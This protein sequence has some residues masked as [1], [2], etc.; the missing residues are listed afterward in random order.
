MA[1]D[2]PPASGGWREGDPVGRRRSADLGALALESGAVLPGLRMA[3]ETWGPPPRDAE[4][5]VLVLHALTGDSHVVGDAGPGHPT[6]GWWPSLVGPGA[7]LDTDRFHVVAPNVLGGCQGSTG[8]SSRAP[9]GAPWGSRFP[10]VTVRDQVA[11]EALLADHLGVGAWHLVVGGSMGGMRAVEWAATHPARVQRLLAVATGA[12]ATADQIAWWSAESAAVRGDAGWR[13][14]DY[15]GA[16]PGEGPH[17]GLGLARRIAHLTYRTALE[18]ELRFGHQ[19]QPGEE[20]LGGGRFAVESYLDHAAAKLVRRFDAGSYVALSGSMRSHD[21]GRGR[22]GVARALGAV[23]AAARVVAV[24]SDRLFPP[25]LSDEL[26]AHLPGAAGVD[27]V[28]SPYG[29]DAFLLETGAVGAAARE[30]A[31]APVPRADR[32]PAPAPAPAPVPRGLQDARAGAGEP[33]P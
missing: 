23:T 25:E 4:G 2:R 31:A 9:D 20:P 8:P 24:D 13:G 15:H 6:P 26:A 18:L 22:G 30:L 21:V 28:P 16:G 3:Y 7:P 32:S 27:L 5:C 33:R 19:P 14:G 10:L 12:R 17:G 1:P 29:H 11:A